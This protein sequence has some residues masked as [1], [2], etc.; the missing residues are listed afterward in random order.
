MKILRSILTDK[1]HLENIDIN[2]DIDKDILETITINIDIDEDI[3]GKEINFSAD[4][5]LFHS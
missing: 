5:R 2:S 3:L 4:L 1:D